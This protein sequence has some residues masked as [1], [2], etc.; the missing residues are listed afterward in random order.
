MAYGAFHKIKPTSRVVQLV[1]GA[2]NIISSITTH[3]S[4]EQSLANIHHMV[5][6]KDDV[7]KIRELNRDCFRVS[8]ELALF[9]SAFRNKHEMALVN[10]LQNRLR[11]IEKRCA[12]AVDHLKVDDAINNNLS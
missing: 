1:H 6:A 8:K 4:D 3:I 2:K 9:H 7:A 11:D 12:C 10:D 5:M